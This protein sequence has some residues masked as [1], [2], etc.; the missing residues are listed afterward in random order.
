MPSPLPGMDPF[1]EG[2][3]WSDFHHG[4]IEDLRSALTPQV[5]PR[6]VVEVEVHVY[7]E[8]EPGGEVAVIQPDAFLLEAQRRE[9]PS[10]G[11]VA[12]ATAVAI[13]PALLTAPIPEE[14]RVAFLTVRER[15]TREVV[16]VIEVLSSFNKRSGGRGRRKYLRKREAV[17]QSAAHLIELDLLRGGRRLP[18]VEPLPAGDYYAFVSREWRRPQV[19]VYAWLLPHPLPALPVPLAADDPDVTLDLQAIFNT[20]YDRAGYDYSLDYRRAVEPPRS[21][22]VAAWVQERLAGW[23]EGQRGGA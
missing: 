19:E 15:E 21:E 1:I 16:T 18:M 14:R 5:R 13:E 4:F 9:V 23:G 12:T 6:Y 3:R 20:V 8:Y 17:L 22:P 7:V 2:Q 10:G 11:G